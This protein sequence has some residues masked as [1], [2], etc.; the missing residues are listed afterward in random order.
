MRAGRTILAGPGAFPNRLRRAMMAGIFLEVS[1]APRSAALL[2]PVL[3]GAL[4]A[5][6][7]G[8]IQDNS[9]LVEEAYNQEPGVVQHIS[10]F[11]RDRTSRDWLFTFT[12]EWPAPGI[13]HQLSYTVPFQ[14]L[15]ASPDGRRAVGDVLLNYRYQLLGDGEARVAIA[16]RL[17]LALPTGDE[18]QGRGA[19]AP[20]LQGLVP[21]SVVLGPACVAHFNVG[22]S[23]TPGA[24]NAAGDKADLTSWT[25][26]QSF[27]WLAHPNANAMLEFAYT[28]GEAVAGP[29][30]RERVETFYVNPGLRFAIN[31]RSGLQIVPGIAFPIGVGPSRGDR[32]VFLYLSFEHPM[33]KP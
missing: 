20:G 32:S 4:G 22:A 28:S 11:M 25:L 31:F 8:P 3:A 30:R 9:F 33:W 29:G 15:S 27:V 17:S 16:P 2:I 18:R 19:G 21:I 24:R 13:T 1:M 5:Q 10:T 7:P 14:R 12:Q 26:G 6:E 23:F